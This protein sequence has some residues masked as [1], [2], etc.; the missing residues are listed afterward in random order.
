MNVK[1]YSS[2]AYAV[3]PR[4]FEHNG[5]LHRVKKIARSWR[6]PGHIHFYVRDEFDE[7]FGLS[8][9]ETQDVWNIRTFGETCPPK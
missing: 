1:T 7:F 6:T 2:F 5:T 4:S 9:D 8:Y 3:E